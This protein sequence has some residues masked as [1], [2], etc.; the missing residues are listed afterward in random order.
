MH[1][2]AYCPVLFHI[3]K[4]YE[5]ML[6]YRI[7]QIKTAHFEKK[8]LHILKHSMK[9]EIREYQFPEVV[10]LKKNEQYCGILR[11]RINLQEEAIKVITGIL[12]K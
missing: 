5:D 12:S 6:S 3:K 8:R 7:H 2:K 11:Q 4:T 9:Q 10:Q 1:F